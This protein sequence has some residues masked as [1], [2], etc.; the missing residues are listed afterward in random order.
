[1]KIFQVEIFS[2]RKSELNMTKTN[3]IIN[4]INDLKEENGVIM[5]VNAG[6]VIVKD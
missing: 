2:E 6:I 4:Y 1:M 5:P 3:N